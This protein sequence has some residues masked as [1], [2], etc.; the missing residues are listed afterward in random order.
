[1]ESIQPMQTFVA[2]KKA[3]THKQVK[4]ISIEIDKM[5]QTMR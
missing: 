3:V 5:M 2:W 1:M 4:S